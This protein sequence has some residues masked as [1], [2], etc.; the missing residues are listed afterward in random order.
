MGKLSILNELKLKVYSLWGVKKEFRLKVFFLAFT[1]LLMSACLAIWRPLKISIFSK[2]VGSE[3]VPDAK[4]YGLLFLIP[5]IILYSKLVDWL[6]RH[7]LVYCFTLFHAF[8]GLIFYYFL[9]HPVYGIANTDMNPKRLVGWFFYFFMESFNAFL[10]T[11][12]WSFADSINNP[13]DA[14]NYYGILVSGSKIG[15]IMS[16]GLLYLALTTIQRG[17]DHVILPNALLIGSLLLFGAAASIFF[18]MKKVPGYYMHGYEAVYQEEKGHV[19]EK[20]SFWQALKGSIDGLLIMI[21]NPYV[22]GIFAL[23]LIYETII[24]IFDY[25]VLRTADY[26]NP[27]A[28]SLTAFYALYYLLMNSVGLIISIFGTTPIL[29]LL[30]IRLSLFIFPLT[31]IGILIITLFFPYAGVLFGALVCLRALNYALNHPTREVLYIPTVKAIK[32]KAKAWTDA[33]GSRIAKG[34]GSVFNI[35][36]KQTAPALALL[37]SITFSLGLVSIWLIVV[38]FLGKTLQ[39]AIDNKKVIGKED[40]Q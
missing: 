30:G 4:L 12:F 15:S 5:L 40:N 35:S 13:K 32:F 18:L 31:C 22:L 10:S 8:G 38:Y 17:Q 3:F 2:I 7:Q 29:R 16:A 19:K 37:Y 36:L 20:Q 1:F 39:N 26:A 27:T 9:A 28:G 24:V 14:K 11:V 25:R 6:R 23:V 34:C 21:R 33:F